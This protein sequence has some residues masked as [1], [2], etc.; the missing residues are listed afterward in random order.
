MNKNK[1]TLSVGIPAYNEENFISETIESILNQTH[2]CEIVVV[3]DSS[4]DR[5]FEVSCD[6]DFITAL[7]FERTGRETKYVTSGTHSASS[8]GTT[9]ETVNSKCIVTGKQIGRAHV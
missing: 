5:T 7:V 2:K 3:N 4:T 6:K 1:H 9:S 8:L